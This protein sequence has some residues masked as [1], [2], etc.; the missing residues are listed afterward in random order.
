MKKIIKFGDWFTWESHD[1]YVDEAMDSTSDI[2]VVINEIL[3]NEDKMKQHNA[4]EHGEVNGVHLYSFTTDEHTF[5][6]HYICDDEH[7]AYLFRNRNEDLPH[8]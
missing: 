2:A 7:Q 3:S 6:C 8:G 1:E 4:K 5:I